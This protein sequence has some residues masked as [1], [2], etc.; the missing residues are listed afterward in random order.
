MR[1]N[2][3][4]PR[5][6][7]FSF[8]PIYS[9]LPFPFP[10]L[11]GRSSTMNLLGPHPTDFF[12]PQADFSSPC[13][14]PSV[15][16]NVIPSPTSIRIAQRFRVDVSTP[17][18]LPSNWQTITALQFYGPLLPSPLGF[19]IF[20]SQSQSERALPL[21]RAS[22]ESPQGPS[23]TEA[24]QLI[25]PYEIATGAPRDPKPQVSNTPF[26]FER[27]PPATSTSDTE[28]KDMLQSLNA[29]ADR[30]P[31]AR[32]AEDLDGRQPQILFPADVPAAKP[33][34]FRTGKG[35]PGRGPRQI[36]IP[37]GIS[38]TA[39]PA[40]D[41]GVPSRRIPFAIST[42]QEMSRHPQPY[43]SVAEMLEIDAVR[44]DDGP[45]GRLL[46]GRIARRRRRGKYSVRTESLGF[47]SEKSELTFELPYEICSP[48]AGTGSRKTCFPEAPAG[49][50]T[51]P[52]TP[53]ALG[54]SGEGYHLRA[55]EAHD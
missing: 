35:V 55:R 51:T 33:L 15:L 34:Q 47:L 17:Q 9:G 43:V 52:S 13:A 36:L 14:L 29:M 41:L 4:H 30:L 27:S 16:F 7:L 46:G 11:R 1:S 53:L 31:G 8:E 10:M 24:R 54:S 22:Y 48:S 2:N 39:T 49:P 18:F 45:L 3:N 23:S 28:T 40:L 26:P 37:P 12:R 19:L 21:S 38:T 20:Q 5:R 50:S 44:R 42:T 6:Q 25:M 32:A